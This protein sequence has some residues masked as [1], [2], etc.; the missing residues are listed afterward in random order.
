MSVWQ[1]SSVSNSLSTQEGALISVSISVDPRYLESLLEALARISFP[2]NP[3]IYH[4]AAVVYVYAGGREESEP[5]TLVEFPAYEARLGEVRRAL[6][7]HSFD[8][9][10]IRVTGMLDEIH[11]DCLPEPAPAGAGY[12]SLYRVKRKAATAAQ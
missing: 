7:A 8:P 10:S 6:E 1:D 9:G 2:I 12:V 5:V 11:A 3:Q 4:D